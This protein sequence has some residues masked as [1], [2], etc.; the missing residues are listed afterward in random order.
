MT[1]YLLDPGGEAHSSH[2][3]YLDRA[4]LDHCRGAGVDARV[5]CR[6]NM[7]AEFSEWVPEAEPAFT[8][9]PYQISA[10]LQE[11]ERIAGTGAATRFAAELSA[12][13]GDRL[14]PDD[15][16]VMHTATFVHL[17]GL[18]AWLRHR[19]DPS[20]R[21][22][23]ILRFEPAWRASTP[24]EAANCV[25]AYRHGLMALAAV[26]GDRLR[27]CCDSAP[28]RRAFEALG[29]CRVREIPISVDLPDT[30]AIEAL[31]QPPKDRLVFG[32]FGEARG[33]KGFAN[34]VRVMPAMIAVAPWIR[35]L[36]QV[37]DIDRMP[38]FSPDRLPAQVELVPEA[39]PKDAFYRLLST[40]HFVLVP[41]DP[42][43]YRYR[44]SHILV[45]ALGIGRP[46][47][48]VAGGWIGEEVASV[49]GGGVEF[50]E[51]FTAEALYSA[52]GRAIGNANRLSAEARTNAVNWRRR[53]G[54]RHFLAAFLDPRR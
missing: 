12:F 10:H 13:I 32:F 42:V 49:G 54:L 22:E 23:I 5:G 8:V 33:E 38:E 2:H 3:A 51:D 30:D 4:I 44:T 25:A 47:V 36:L 15:I 27:V 16:L 9:S 18:A 39:L 40:V 37:P 1:L 29:V 45:E 31:P 19:G 53:H 48:S 50:A 35:F 21:I 34:L 26:A 11:A 43:A 7:T 24:A 46:V 41:Y 14:D 28:L 52:L 6:V 20:P 17:I